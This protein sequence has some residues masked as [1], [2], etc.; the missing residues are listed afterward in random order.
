MATPTLLSGVFAAIV[1]PL[2]PDFSPDLDA[3][4]NLIEFLANRGCHGVLLMGTTGEGP[5]FSTDERLSILRRSVEVRNSLQDFQL[6]AG[7]GT[8]SLEETIFLTHEAFE[9]G[10]EG[11]VVL[12]PYYFRKAPEAGLFSWFS[13]VLDKA[14]PADGLLLGYHIPPVIGFGFTIDLL[15]RLKDA[16]PTKFAGI[17]DSSGD[18]E[19]ARSL[20]A[21]FGTSMKVLNGNDRL[22]NLALQSGARGCITAVANL[23]SPLHRQIWDNFQK[24]ILDEITQDKLSSAR[25]VLDR[26]TPFPPLIKMML[27]RLHGFPLWKVKPPLLDFDPDKDEIVISEFLA[28]LE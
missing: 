2:K 16:Y 10:F 4:T 17:K 28:S 27:S 15:A 14:V 5:S 25:E 23:L 19:W 11:V 22:F 9:L 3:L 18:P 21:R 7:T 8:P 20:G 1:T 6:L 26:Y 24:G 12:P 13:R